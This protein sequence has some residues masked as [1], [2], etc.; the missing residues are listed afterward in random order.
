MNI[1]L[2]VILIVAGVILL[3]LE[4]FLLPGFGIAGIT[5][6][7]SL[8]GAVAAAYLRIGATAGHITLAA[9]IVAAAL[10]VYG[11]LKS[12]ALQKMA[13]DTS[14]D[15]QVTSASPGRKIA[16][17]ERDAKVMDAE[18]EKEREEKATAN[19]EDIGEPQV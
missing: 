10:A 3:L 14:I 16:D 5:G 13:L 1:A 15:S 6:F 19:A 18:R 7:L 11:F 4:L 9:A 8:A 2:V 17:L 12:H